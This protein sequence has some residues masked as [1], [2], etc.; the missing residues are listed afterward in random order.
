MHLLGPSQVPT[1]VRVPL[2]DNRCR[3]QKTEAG[4]PLA[5]RPGLGNTPTFTSPPG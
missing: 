1:E 2:L 3:N 4:S 5:L